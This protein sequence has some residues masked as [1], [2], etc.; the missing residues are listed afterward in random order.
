MAQGFSPQVS[1][2][3]YKVIGVDRSATRDEIK[4]AFHLM[5]KKAHPDKTHNPHT[6][7]TMKML[8]KIKSVLL[9]SDIEKR[10]YDEELSRKVDTSIPLFMRE[11]RGDY[12]L[13]PGITLL[14]NL[15]T[16]PLYIA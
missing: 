2:D 6:E 8:N 5:A 16:V 9:D 7:D 1:T 12:L 4:K 3:Y 13:P 11:N 10:K 14:A 15:S